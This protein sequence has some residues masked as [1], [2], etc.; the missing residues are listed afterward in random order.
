MNHSSTCAAYEARY[1]L[2]FISLFNRGRGYAFPCDAKGHV[3]LDDLSLQSRLNY[4]YAR[5]VVGNELS[6]PTVTL[7]P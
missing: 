5:V 2:R 4:F 7:V 6:V 3:E 1:E